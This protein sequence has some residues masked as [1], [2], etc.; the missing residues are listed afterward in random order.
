MQTHNLT[1]FIEKLIEL[2]IL[3]RKIPITEE[4]P[5]KSK[6][7]LYFIKDN[8]F[9]FWF[10]YVFPYQNYLETGRYD[11]ILNKIK[12]D[13]DIFVSFTLEE[14]ILEY[15]YDLDIPF[16]IYK[17]GKW[18]DKDTEIDVVAVGEDSILFGECKYWDSPVGT[19]VLYQLKEKA[20]KVDWKKG[21]RKEYYAVFSKSG[22]TKEIID[23]SKKDKDIFLFDFNDF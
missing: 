23:L 21:K 16:H 1:S 11:Y 13:F 17:A 3:E 15:I 6:K 8:F 7:G 20:K 14:V 19:N 12:S 5:E 18:W 10:K 2:D 22:F 4:N 9:N